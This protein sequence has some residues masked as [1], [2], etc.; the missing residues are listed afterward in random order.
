MQLPPDE[1]S[2]ELDSLPEV[3][4]ISTTGGMILPKLDELPIPGGAFDKDALE[5]YDD[6]VDWLDLE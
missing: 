3:A 1:D 6:A 2:S 4:S 5:H